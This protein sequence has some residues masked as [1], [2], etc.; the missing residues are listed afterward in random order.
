M[1]RP[2]AVTFKG[3]PLT[4][5]G[6]ELKV[7]DA[8]PDFSVVGHDLSPVKLA[9]L[10]GKAKIVSVVPSIDTPVCDTQTRRFNK[11]AASLSGVKIYTVSMD[12]PFAQ[13]RWCAAAGV[14]KVV[15]LSDY[16]SGSFGRSFGTL[17]K[18]LH[19]DTRALFVLDENSVVRHVEYVPEVTS[20][21]DY[22]AAL[23]AAR[24]VAGC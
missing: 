22:D 6:P 11:E 15:M 4:L 2:Q 13:S 18:E 14:D 23:Q 24:K 9:D 20:H 3:N 7:G 17:I 12:L 21:P 10:K 19:L 1:E 5:L 8:A 16:Q